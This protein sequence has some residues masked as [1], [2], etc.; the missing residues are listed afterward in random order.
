MMAND[1]VTTTATSSMGNSLANML[2]FVIDSA[3]MKGVNTALPV[4]VDAVYPG[5]TGPVG[6]VD[7]TPL[8]S[9]LDAARK[10]QLRATVYNVPYLR[11][12]GGIAALI[13]DPAPG[14]IGI[15]IFAQDDISRVVTGIKGPVQ[16][17]SYRNFD[18]ADAMYIGGIVNK[19]PEIYLELSQDKVAT[20]H[21]PARVVVNT[22]EAVIN[23]RT[24]V[25]VNSPLSRFN[26]SVEVS[27][28][29]SWG[30]RGSGLNNGRARISHGLDVEQGVTVQQG[31]AN[32]GGALSSNGIVL[33]THV[34]G[35]V[36]TGGGSTGAPR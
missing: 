15:A 10:N 30:K 26:G 21:A 7:V 9:Q 14:D 29:L 32:T 3:L 4:R 22:N 18:M 31:L 33:D 16:P 28:N 36:E 25:T 11:V 1:T 13:I 5:G 12:Q 20:L 23:A 35:G 34:H 19:Q 27:E 2:Q 6:R 24:S 8:V 17:G